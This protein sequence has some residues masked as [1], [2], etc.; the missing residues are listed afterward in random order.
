MLPTVRSPLGSPGV[1]ALPAARP[2]AIHPQRMD[3]CA[4]V[5]VAPRG[6]ARMPLV[7]GDWPRGYRQVTDGPSRPLRR[8]LPVLVRSFDEFERIFGGLESPGLLAASVASYFEQGGRLAWIVRV[9]HDRPAPFLDGRAQGAVTGIFA[10][11]VAFTART[12][13]AWGNALR[14]TLSFTTTTLAFTL[15]G[16][17]LLVELRA[18]VSIGTTLRF[19]DALGAQALA[20]VTGMARARDAQRARERWQLAFDAAPVAPV[21]AELVEARIDIDDG[22]GRRESFDHLALAADHPESLANVLCDRSALL[23]PDAAWAATTLVPATAR[24]ELLRAT[25]APFAGGDDAWGAIVPE[26]FLDAAWTPADELP[27]GGVCALAQTAS[28][29]QLVVPDLYLPSQWAG[30]DVVQDPPAGGAGAEFGPCVDVVAAPPAADVAPSVLTG[31]V[32]DPLTQAGLDAIA[33]LQQRV[34]DVCEA[35]QS[36]VALLDVPPDLSQSRIERWRAAFDSAWA[37]AY[38]PWLIPTRRHDD[39]EDVATNRPRRL[40]P[41]AVAAGIVARRE[42]TYDLPYGPANEVANSV[43]HVAEAQ[44][45]GRADVLQPLSINCFVRRQEGIAL[46]AA[47]TLARDGDWRQLSVR[48]MV[49]MIRRALVAQTQ[50]AV[51]EPNGPAL[52]RD[53]VHA[54]QGLLRGLFR[55]GAFAGATEAESFF[56]RVLADA[57]RQDAGQLVI[58]IGVAPAE[59]LEFILVRLARDG[60]GTLTLEE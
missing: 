5:G 10:T 8:S 28:A 47:R 46:V 22:D 58:E 41:S 56:V 42:R 39:D 51:F 30:E 26:D 6:P 57:P 7:D 16:A 52:Q 23:W 27:G 31:L 35:T 4:F 9:V 59:P 21:R 18:P 2:P 12:E 33:A 54:I 34:V 3:V 48:R 44:P 17:Q 15:A 29:T 40:P 55:A 53:L 32:L 60:D 24:V 13:G 1:F 11:P 49:L 50:W 19:T 45:P 43:I 20:R 25:S 36:L 14:A 37:A 38:H